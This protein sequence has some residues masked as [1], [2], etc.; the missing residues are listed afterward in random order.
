MGALW[1]WYYGVPLQPTPYQWWA[2]NLFN[3]YKKAL[4]FCM[5]GLEST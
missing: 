3:T 4:T 2:L 5:S 1:G